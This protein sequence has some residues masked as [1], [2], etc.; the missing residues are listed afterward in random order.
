[1]AYI[2]GL[3]ITG[4]FFLVLH[5]FTELNKK[6]KAIVTAIVA[7]MIA[8]G[9]IFNAYSDAQ[10]KQRVEVSTKFQQGHTITCDGVDV[11]STNFT[12]STGTFTFIGKR[13]TPFYGQMISGTECE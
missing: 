11:N 13:E 2:L 7:A 4:V 10:N 6:Q 9:I 8:F 3:I 1:M 12:M 5:Y